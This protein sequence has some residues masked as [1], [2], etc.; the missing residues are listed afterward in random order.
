MKPDPEQAAAQ[1]GKTLRAVAAFKRRE[2]LLRQWLLVAAVAVVA[3]LVVVGDPS[4]WVEGLPEEPPVEVV[5]QAATKAMTRTTAS[6][7]ITAGRGR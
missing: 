4:G 5:V 1:I 6:R 2:K 3:V 7:P